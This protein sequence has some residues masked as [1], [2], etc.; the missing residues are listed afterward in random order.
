MRLKIR[1]NAA[2]L[3]LAKEL[4][5]ERSLYIAEQLPQP[6]SANEREIEESHL[7][8]FEDAKFLEK[9]R[10]ADISIAFTTNGPTP[11]KRSLK[12]TEHKC[13]TCKKR[14]MTQESLARHQKVCEM[15]IIGKFDAQFRHLI[16]LT[17][18]QGI[19][20]NEFVLRTIKLIFDTQ[21]DLARIVNKTG[22]NVN[23][24][25][26]VTMEAQRSYQSPD[27]GYSSDVGA[28]RQVG[29]M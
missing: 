29:N 28:S 10:G 26:K 25:S 20:T 27:F 12:V 7:E 19:T 4:A 21:K 23:S 22:T 16:G 5:C 1:T 15:T 13:E 8:L 18:V 2:N 9:F 24:I 11:T 3:R 17:Y 14:M 6:V